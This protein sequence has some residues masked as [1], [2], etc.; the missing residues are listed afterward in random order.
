M[1]KQASSGGRLMVSIYKILKQAGRMFLWTG[2]A[3]SVAQKLVAASLSLSLFFS[4]F[5][6]TFSCNRQRICPVTWG[7]KSTARSLVGENTQS[8]GNLK[9][10]EAENL[11][12][13]NAQQVRLDFE[14]LI[15]HQEGVLGGSISASL[16]EQSTGYSSRR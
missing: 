11:H 13:L 5:L 12:S 14:I 1:C 15:Y 6:M 7:C 9:E 8:E 3:V 2:L 16:I 4:F 10:G